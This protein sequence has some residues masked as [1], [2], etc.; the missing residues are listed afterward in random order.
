MQI[1]FLTGP[2]TLSLSVVVPAYN[3]EKRLPPM[4]DEAIPFLEQRMK[5]DSSF[6]YEII[7]VDDGSKDKTS[8]V[9]QNYARRF[10][11]KLRVLTLK[12]NRGKGGAVRRGMLCSRGERILMVDADGATQFS[13]VT[14]LEEKLDQIIDDRGMGIVVGSRAH[15]E[16]EAKA[17]RKI[18]RII[19]MHVFHLLVLLCV[20]K[21]RDTQCG[22]KLFSRQSASLLAHIA[23]NVERWAFDVELLFVAQQHKIPIHEVAV[24]WQEID[25][26]TL[27]PLTAAIQMAKDIIRIRTL[28]ALGIW[29]A[30]AP[31]DD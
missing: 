15:M 28:Y 16:E 1:S 2:A 26:S 20:A 3:E 24:N 12:R 9:G 27:N 8:E 4:L 18:H 25:G 31:S 14:R 6:S 23:F 30:K 29:K 21:V 5:E 17:E 10:P 19:M 22:F 11:G 13:E 7:I